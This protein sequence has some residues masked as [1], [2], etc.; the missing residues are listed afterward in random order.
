MI[1]TPSPGE[2]MDIFAAGDSKDEQDIL[3]IPSLNSWH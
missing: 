1:I 3:F 2:I